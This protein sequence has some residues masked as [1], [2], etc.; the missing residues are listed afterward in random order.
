MRKTKFV[1]VFDGI[2]CAR[3]AAER[4]EIKIGEYLYSE[5]DIPAIEIGNKNYP[6]SVALGDIVNVDPYDLGFVDIFVGG[7]PCQSFSNMGNGKGF[8][9]KSGLFWHYVRILRVLKNINPNIEFLLENVKMR[10][11]WAA[12]ITK[13]LGVEPV[14]INSSFFSGQKRQRLYWTN[15]EFDKNFQDKGIAL[16][17]VLEKQV[18]ERYFLKGKRLENWVR[19]SP[20]RIKKCFSSLD[21]GKAIC[22]TARQF[23]NWY[24]N[25]VTENGRVRQLTP[26]ECERLQN[27]PDNYTEGIIESERYRQLGNGWTV[28]VVAH[29][30]KGSRFSNY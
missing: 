28:D 6:N 3:V 16:Q 22:M 20:M 18:D 10:K 27:L 17:D 9:G 29:I 25:H 26:I 2:R 4:A 5:I 30:L 23:A 21:A 15:I 7:S 14:L 8:E 24:G 13:E 11:E 19:T 12:M 1:S